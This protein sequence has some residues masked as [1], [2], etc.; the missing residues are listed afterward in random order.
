MFQDKEERDV[1]MIRLAN[2]KVHSVSLVMFKPP[3]RITQR[4]CS[5]LQSGIMNMQSANGPGARSPSLSIT[6]VT[7]CDRTLAL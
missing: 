7:F 1:L 3:L 4:N 2:F 6:G 5:I